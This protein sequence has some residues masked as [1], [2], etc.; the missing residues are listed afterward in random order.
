MGCN[1]VLSPKIIHKGISM[2]LQNVKNKAFVYGCI[3]L[4]IMHKVL[5]TEKAHIG[6]YVERCYSWETDCFRM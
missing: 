2:N 3:E 5:N 6:R 1:Q 4:L